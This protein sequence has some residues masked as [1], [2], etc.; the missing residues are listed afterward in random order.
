MAIWWVFLAGVL[1]LAVVL[2]GFIAALVIS[3]RRV[4]RVERE[5]AR[6]LLA[7]QEAERAWV[8]R[9]VH[10][11]VLQRVFAVQEALHRVAMGLPEQ[12]PAKSART[13]EALREDLDD[14]NYVLRGVA[15]RL[16]PT[17]VE[18][19]GLVAGLEELARVGIHD[20]DIT[21]TVP[22]R[23]VS[24]RWDA[25]LAAYRIAYEALR[26]VAYHSGVRQAVVILAVQ[27][28]WIHLTVEDAGR[29]FDLDGKGPEAGLGLVSMQERAAAAGGQFDLTTEPGKGTRVEARFPLAAASNSQ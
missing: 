19:A 11:D 9:E 25:A 2:I 1:A 5:H 15:R 3:Q 26:N 22:D 10:D 18:R 4:L 23:A 28:G 13:L 17:V 7:A 20:L 27:D 12:E 24:L 14:V 8:A 21:L 16:H 6:K 29:G